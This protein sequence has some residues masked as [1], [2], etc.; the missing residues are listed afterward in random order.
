MME[1]N[2]RSTRP[3][4][5]T[6]QRSPDSFLRRTASLHG[7]LFMLATEIIVSVAF[8]NYFCRSFKISRALI[9][10]HL[11]L[12]TGLL[13]IAALA[14]GLLL[15]NRR[16]RDSGFARYFLVMAPVL[17][18]VLLLALYLFDFASNLWMGSNINYKLAGLYFS[19]LSSGHDILLLSRWVY[20]SLAAFAILI[21][22]VYLALAK[23]I[24]KGL[25]ELLLPG[26]PTSLFGSRNR[27]LRSYAIIG[28]VLLG[29]AG[30]FYILWR[31]APYSELISSDPIVA[32]VRSTTEV[33]DANY[34][35][36]LS[37]LTEQEQ[38]CRANYPREQTFEKKNVVIIIVDALRP[39]H[40]GVYGYNR[41]TTP[42]L[43]S[44]FE[45][46]ELRKVEF[47]TSTCAASKCGIVSTLYSKTL[48]RQIVADFKLQDLLHDQGYKTYF[49]LTGN[50]SGQGIKEMHGPELT[51]YF[52]ATNSVRYAGQDDRLIFEGFEKVPDY[53][54]TPGFFYIHLMSTHLSGIKQEAY[55]VY[56]P[57]DV[58][59][60]WKA[61]VRGELDRTSVIN[62]YDNGVIQ[63]DATIKEIFSVLGKKGYL[64]DSIVV[65]LADHG[66]GLGERGK[67]SYGHGS[68][69]QEF[70]RIPLLI[71]DKSPTK[72]GNLKFAT[73]IDVAPTIVDRLG[74][75][76]PVCWQGA[77]LLDGNIKAVTT[78]QT[79]LRHHPCYA[80]LYRTDATIYKYMFCT[81]D[82]REELYDLTSDP[83]EQLNLIDVAEPALVQRMRNELALSLAD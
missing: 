47:A 52:D 46:G 68:L 43:Q 22:A 12:V 35:A 21:L 67:A 34:P 24:F 74:L 69:Y 31:R 53:T 61:I 20:F 37:R 64:Q 60:N 65:I 41:P 54:G 62:N 51:L 82:K 79:Y 32:F 9:A 59:S 36:F 78:H 28:L 58:K 55:R 6:T 39:D 56:Q 50:H 77:S 33:Y 16:I 40:T 45:T 81:V 42:F 57:S 3:G 4:P 27:R 83:S 73:Q 14:P 80:V 75:P 18:F 25:E 48:R 10:I 19:Q 70:I 66:E 15:Y 76:I 72:Y 13:V 5:L 2:V 23:T 29:Y 17:V 49:I 7:L 1:D 44:L 71:Y 11:P 63:A 8:I 30:F 26:H 38:R